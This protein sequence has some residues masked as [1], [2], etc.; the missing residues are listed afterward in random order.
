MSVFSGFTSD[1]WKLCR[2][3]DGVKRELKPKHGYVITATQWIETHGLNARVTNEKLDAMM[4]SAETL[5]E[6]M[7]KKEAQGL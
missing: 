4:P 1:H 6:W 3:F 7:S 5:A 2:T